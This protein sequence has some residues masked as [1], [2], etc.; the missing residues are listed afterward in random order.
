MSTNNQ[1]TPAT[2]T[3]LEGAEL[4]IRRAGIVQNETVEGKQL[5][6]ICGFSYGKDSKKAIDRQIEKHAFSEGKDFSTSMSKTSGR[7][8]YTYQF[9]INAANHVLLAAMTQEGK[10]AR[11]DAINAKFEECFGKIEPAQPAQPVEIDYDR[12]VKTVLATLKEVKM[13]KEPK[14]KKKE[15]VT[16]D[17]AFKVLETRLINATGGKKLYRSSLAQKLNAK[18]FSEAVLSVAGKLDPSAAVDVVIAKSEILKADGNK[19]FI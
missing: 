14:P 5:L 8:S 17:N 11:Q 12:I 3:T 1:N 7:P 4:A 19:V 16:P 18:K 9:T 2:I 10:A 6:D 15:P 13:L